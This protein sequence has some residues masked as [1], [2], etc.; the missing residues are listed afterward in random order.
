MSTFPVSTAASLLGP[1]ASTAGKVQ[2]L[3]VLIGCLPVSHDTASPL[4]AELRK[5]RGAVSQLLQRLSSG[6][7]TFSDDAVDTMKSVLT[8]GDEILAGM[9]NSIRLYVSE[10]S[11]HPWN[12]QTAERY[13]RMVETQSQA[14]TILSEVVEL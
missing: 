9:G 6:S 14:L 10:P 1:C 2:D 11:Q 12:V 7:A 8:A 3:L 13:T 4:A 5:L